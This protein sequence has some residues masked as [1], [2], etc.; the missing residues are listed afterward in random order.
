MADM[1]QPWH[2]LKPSGELSGRLWLCFPSKAA[3]WDGA[4]DGG[5]SIDWPR[6]MCPLPRDV[7]RP[8]GW[9]PGPLSLIV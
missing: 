7:Q 2:L 9:N 6:L 1:G 3:Q 5:I 8:Q 4:P